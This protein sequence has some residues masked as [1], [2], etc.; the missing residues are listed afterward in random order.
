MLLT[1]RLLVVLGCAALLLLSDCRKKDNDHNGVNAGKEQDVHISNCVV[2]P[3]PTLHTRGSVAAADT[4][5]WYNDDNIEYTPEFIG[6]SPF[7]SSVNPIPAKGYSDVEILSET[8]VN[9]CP[10][11]MVCD[12]T[13]KL[14]KDDGSYC[15][16]I[17]KNRAVNQF[18]MHVKG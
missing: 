10:G 6:D 17:V 13:Y 5:V 15:S 14:K 18:I 3:E 16:Y 4:M 9:N 8:T 1:K 7:S 11:S 2:K 12:F